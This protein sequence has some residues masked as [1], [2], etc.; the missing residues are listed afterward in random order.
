MD[1][2]SPGKLMMSENGSSCHRNGNCLICGKSMKNGEPYYDISSPYTH[3]SL[4]QQ[5]ITEAI[6]C[7]L[8]CVLIQSVMLCKTCWNLLDIVDT[9]QVQLKFK[10][11]EIKT[12]Y[13]NSTPGTIEN[14][15]SNS[16]PEDSEGKFSSPA[17]LEISQNVESSSTAVDIIDI[18][19][20]PVTEI[21][22][23]LTLL[24]KVGSE[25]TLKTPVQENIDI[26]V[27]PKKRDKGILT[28]KDLMCQICE[29]HFEKR[30]YLMDHL[31]RVHKS[32]VYH[33]DGCK[34]RYMFKEE[35]LNHQLNCDLYKALKSPDKQPTAQNKKLFTK[36]KKNNQ[37]QQCD[38]YFLTQTLLKIHIKNVHEGQNITSDTFDETKVENPVNCSLCNITINNE[39][40]LAIHQ[41]SVHGFERPWNCN[42][43]GKNFARHLE[44]VNHKR[45]HS[46][47]KPFQCDTCGA[48][49]N[50]K[51][52][53]HTHV[54]HI[55][56]GERRYEC[57]ICHMKFRRKRLLDCHMN[58]KHKFERPYACKLCSATFVYPEHVRKHELTHVEGKK[59]NC[60][61]CE[62]SFKSKTSL[63][64]HKAYHR[65][66][67]N[68]QCLSCPQ[69]FASKDLLLNH[70]KSYNHPRGVFS[71]QNQEVVIP[72]ED[73][74][75]TLTLSF[76]DP[77]DEGAIENENTYENVVFILPEQN[78]ED[79]S[80]CFAEDGQTVIVSAI[81]FWET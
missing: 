74:C 70:L 26:I 79:G 61:E 56:L 25:D 42:T 76:M 67:S 22:E 60:D 10:K 34:D 44:L 50:Q 81:C 73:K 27:P 38:Q 41:G 54:R 66:C 71:N 32:A 80:L 75:E 20:K 12:L 64:N 43:C 19:A 69:Y 6:F 11:S 63:E 77:I 4:S 47:D 2:K 68:Y 62:K 39:Y 45:I 57:S 37:C 52:N 15:L 30:R 35:L 58:S 53:L 55:H 14:D 28:S 8:G 31:R 33:C 3:T 5:H 72:V 16:K 36:R 29:K 23:N 78:V 40:A 17:H 21:S 48:R 46:G 7:V 65:P 51:Q 9:L 59:F 49:F 1:V 18:I 13:Q 24:T